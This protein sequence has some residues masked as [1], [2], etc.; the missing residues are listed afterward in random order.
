MIEFNENIEEVLPYNRESYVEYLNEDYE[1]EPEWCGVSFQLNL[2][3]REFGLVKFLKFYEP[4]FK[5]VLLNFNNGGRWLVNHDYEGQDWFPNVENTLSSLRNLF[6]Q[7]KIPNTFRGVLILE[8]DDLLEFSK[9]L[10]SYPYAMF[11]EDGVLYSDLD[12]S[13]N[14]SQ[15]IIKISGHWN[16][17]LLSTDK[18]LLRKTIEENSS[19]KFTIKEYRGTS[20]MSGTRMHQ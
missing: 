3:E 2:E 10:L 9:D 8:T 20:F 15:F 1:S 14:E 12:I 4:L 13:S 6:Q 11:K 7:N 18:E 17:D 16:I 19:D 5:N